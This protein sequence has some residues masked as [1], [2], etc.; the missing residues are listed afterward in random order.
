MISIEQV[1]AHAVR[2]A[3]NTI[4][5]FTD[6]KVWLDNHDRDLTFLGLEVD[7]QIAE[8]L[9][10]LFWRSI[11]RESGSYTLLNADFA[12]ASTYD[13]AV[14]MKWSFEVGMAQRLGERL[15]LLKS[16]RDFAQHQIGTSLVLAKKLAD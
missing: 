5:H 7:V 2:H 6:T 9:T 12:L 15:K 1:G 11:D 8:Y 16:K 3:G 14:R 4:A 13:Q 10:L